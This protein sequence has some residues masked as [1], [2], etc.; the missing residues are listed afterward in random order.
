MQI[1]SLIELVKR[2]NVITNMKEKISAPKDVYAIFREKLMNE[3]RENFFVLLLD[4]KNKIIKS[5][6]ISLGILDASIVHAREIFR[7]AIKHSS[8]KIILIH[9][10]PSGDP[11]PSKEDL[12]I[13]KKLMEAGEIIGIEI[14]DHIIIGKEKYWSW[15][16]N[17]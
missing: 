8:S 11:T 16:E 10:H 5:E 7:P 2:Y 3:K 15:N 12:E 13:T 17:F 6:L 4:T 1:S 14:V 9:N